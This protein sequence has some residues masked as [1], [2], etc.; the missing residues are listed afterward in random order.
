LNRDLSPVPASPEFSDGDSPPA[1]PAGVVSAG[2][3]R[4]GAGDSVLLVSTDELLSEQPA[5]MIPAIRIAD[6]ISIMTLLFCI[7]FF[8]W[9][10]V[11]H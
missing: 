10:P 11:M 6:A 9:Y 1:F 8:S 3:A 2:F 5:T 7:L 4:D